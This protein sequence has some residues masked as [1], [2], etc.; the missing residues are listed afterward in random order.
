MLI[1]SNRVNSFLKHTLS[2]IIPC[3]FAVLLCLQLPAQ[4]VLLN[5][6]GAGGFET[7]TTFAA[8]GWTQVASTNPNWYVGTAAL[9]FAGAR[10]A[11]I[12]TSAT[13]FS[14]STT[15]PG[16]RHFYRDIA[17]PAAATNIFL[18]FYAS[19]V[20]SRKIIL[21]DFLYP[22]NKIKHKKCWLLN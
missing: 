21:K 17:I 12:G 22:L 8:N 5:P 10:E 20:A 7:G 3:F 13:N 6:N 2:K 9:P 11:H 15:S 16:A 19:L 18:S 4:T 14:G 1:Y